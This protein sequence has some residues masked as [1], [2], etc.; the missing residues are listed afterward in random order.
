MISSCM[1]IFEF[2]LNNGIRILS[3]VQRYGDDSTSKWQRVWPVWTKGQILLI[4]TYEE[5]DKSSYDLRICRDPT[6]RVIRRPSELSQKYW[7]LLYVQFLTTDRQVVDLQIFLLQKDGE[8]H[9]KR[10]KNKSP[11]KICSEES[12]L[13][14]K[15]NTRD[16][17]H[18]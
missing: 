6:L 4:E 15:T 14:R 11:E 16:I 17:C 13:N 1:I 7:R 10:L 12:Y 2:G 5:T 18:K 9:S 3:R 8:S